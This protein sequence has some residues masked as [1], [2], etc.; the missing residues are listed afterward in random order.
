MPGYRSEP[1][2]F[3]FVEFEETFEEGKIKLGRCQTELNSLPSWMTVLKALQPRFLSGLSIEIA[4][5]EL[6]GFIKSTKDV[7]SNTNFELLSGE[8]LSFIF[9]PV[10]FTSRDK[11]PT[12]QTPFSGELTRWQCISKIGE[13]LVDDRQYAFAPPEGFLREVSRRHLSWDSH[14]CA[15]PE[16][17]FAVQLFAHVAPTPEIHLR[18]DQFKKHIH[19]QM[20][21]WRC[22]SNEADTVHQAVAKDGFAFMLIP[23]VETEP[24]WVSGVITMHGTNPQVGMFHLVMDWREFDQRPIAVALEKSGTLDQLPG[25]EAGEDVW[26][27]IEKLFGHIYAP[28]PEELLVTLPDHVRGVPIN[29][30]RRMIEFL[31]LRKTSCV[32]PSRI[33]KE[34]FKARLNESLGSAAFVTEFHCESFE[35][36]GQIN[37]YA[38]FVEPPLELSSGEFILL[39][40]DKVAQAF[41]SLEPRD[42]EPGHDTR[43]VLFSDGQIEFEKE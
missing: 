4:D 34:E 36:F 8:W 6:E 41:D 20:L 21:P 12:H 9:S 15:C 32:D 24:S 10:Q 37:R 18:A 31:R 26:A 7:I 13:N 23:E 40:K 39:I 19:S 5:R 30:K 35:S 43:G 28:P 11:H 42:C 27:V 2:A 17:D 25:H 16:L 33:N 1:V 29:H 3:R 14:F 38:V 22:L